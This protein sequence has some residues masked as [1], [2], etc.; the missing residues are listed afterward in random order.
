MYIWGMDVMMGPLLDSKDEQRKM[1]LD[2]LLDPYFYYSTEE[3]KWI[4]PEELP[5][6]IEPLRIEL[7]KLKIKERHIYNR[8]EREGPP[9]H[10]KRGP[11]RYKKR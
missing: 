10:G 7:E 3:E 5:A 9:K 2:H 1:E 8:L 6:E 11:G 4:L